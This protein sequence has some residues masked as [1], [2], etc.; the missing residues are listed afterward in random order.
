MMQFGG[1]IVLPS[2]SYITNG[3]VAYWKMNDATGTNAADSSG[4]GNPLSLIGSP[5]WGPGSLIL[6]GSSQ[7]GV[8][9]S[10]SVLTNLDQHDKTICAWIFSTTN[11]GNAQGIV[12]KSDDAVGYSVVSGGGWGGTGWGMWLA[13]D[14]KLTWFIANGDNVPDG[15]GYVEDAGT[16]TIPTNQWCFVTIVS[17]AALSNQFTTPPTAIDFYVNGILSGHNGE[18]FLDSVGTNIIV[19]SPSTVDLKIGKFTHSMST[20]SNYPF[21]GYIRQVAAYNRALSAAEVGTDFL[22]TVGGLTNFLVPY[23]D[24][25]Y[26]KLNTGSSNESAPQTA[27]DSST[28][29]TNNGTIYGTPSSNGIFWNNGI[30]GIP[31]NLSDDPASNNYAS[32][33]FHGQGVNWIDTQNTNLFQFTTNLFTINFWVVPY[34]AGETI[35]QCGSY[36]SNGWYITSGGSYEIIFGTETNGNDTPVITSP[37]AANSTTWAMVSIVRPTLTN[38]IIYINGLQKATD[39]ITPPAPSPGSLLIGISPGATTN[40]FDGDMWGLQ[41]WNEP[42]SPAAIG[43]LYLNTSKAVN[44]P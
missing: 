11:N 9:G 18:A 8:E 15:G 35:M 26:Y 38:A 22:Q 25:L 39:F 1:K 5:S 34:T 4:Y 13:A 24:L 37:G 40:S 19:E 44:Y 43:S 32:L 20:P 41:I 29:G 27:Y 6:D 42:L 16:L 33:H 10:A 28:L 7:Y 3:L 2:G 12:D 30:T 31:G 21:S 17:H 23:P 36:R 14:R